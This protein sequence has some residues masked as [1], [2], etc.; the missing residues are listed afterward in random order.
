MATQPLE[1][2]ACLSP[3][4]NFPS[5]QRP[6]IHFWLFRTLTGVSG[7]MLYSCMCVIFL[8]AHPVVRKKAYR[9]F[10]ITHQLYV[11]FYILCMLH[12][13]QKITGEPRFWMFFLFPGIVFITDKVQVNLYVAGKL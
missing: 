9:F 7:V 2:L 6:D 1:H 10:W 8:F 12:G 3:E 5:D 13:L 11:L 4:I